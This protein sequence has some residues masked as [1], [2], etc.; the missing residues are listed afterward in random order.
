MMRFRYRSPEVL[1]AAVAVALAGCG[2]QP[3]AQPDSHLRQETARPPSAQAA[4]PPTVRPAPLPPPPEA[5]AAEIKYSIIV[6]NQPVRD[7]LLAIA[8]ETKVQ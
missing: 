2:T 7:V 6:A 8:R 3:I 4:I 5:R 1:I